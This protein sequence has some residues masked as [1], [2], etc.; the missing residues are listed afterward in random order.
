MTDQ[1]VRWVFMFIGKFLAVGATCVAVI[2]CVYAVRGW[3]E[4]D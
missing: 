3:L 1:D 4:R 2:A